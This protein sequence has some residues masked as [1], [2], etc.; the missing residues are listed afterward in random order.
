MSIE[1]S[2]AEYRLFKHFGFEKILEH[3]SSVYMCYSVLEHNAFLYPEKYNEKFI[4]ALRTVLIMMDEKP[5]RMT[6]EFDK[7]ILFHIGR[8]LT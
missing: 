5:C 8:K 7:A 2:D 6:P 4:N 1:Y 3:T